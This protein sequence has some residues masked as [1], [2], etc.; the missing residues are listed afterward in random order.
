MEN[1]NPARR[2]IVISTPVGERH[3]H[4]SRGNIGG[5]RKEEG[6]TKEE[7]QGYETADGK[8]R[9]QSLKMVGDASPQYQNTQH[10]DLPAKQIFDSGYYL[11]YEAEVFANS[12]NYLAVFTKHYEL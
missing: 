2:G 7:R 6:G 12:L 8:R 1:G 3:P 5:W 4:T 9:E 10:S 11:A